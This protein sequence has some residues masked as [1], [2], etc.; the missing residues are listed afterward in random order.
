M[1]TCTIYTLWLVL[2]IFCAVTNLATSGTGGS[3]FTGSFTMTK[4]L[5]LEAPQ[6]V[7]Y[8]N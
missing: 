2:A 1:G 7:R 4:S 8:I 5:A 6:W 3:S